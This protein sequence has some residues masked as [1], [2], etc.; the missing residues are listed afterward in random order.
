MSPESESHLP[1]RRDAYKLV[2]PAFRAVLDHKYHRTVSG[3]ENIPDEPAIYAPNHIKIADSLL[4]AASYTE[5]TGIPLRFGAKQE[6][7]DGK[8][9]NDNGKL[10]RSMKWFMEHTHQIPVDRESK[11]LRAFQRLQFEVADRIAYGDSVAL[12]PEGTRS[13][14]GRLHKF[15]SGAARIALALSVPIVPVGLVYDEHSNQRYTDVEITF[16]KPVMPDEYHHLPYTILPNKQKAE[17]LIQ[18]VENRVADLTGMEQSGAF[19]VL[20]KLRHHHEEP[21]K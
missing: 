7:F 21:E 15:K 20:R 5:A 13:D 14:D 11:D 6:Y 9:L 8:G 10:G 4:V 3:I 19:A 1:K 12:H 17:H 16:G 2:Y 18:V